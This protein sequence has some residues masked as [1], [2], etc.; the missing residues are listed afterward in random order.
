[1]VT[2]YLRR[3]YSSFTSHVI[4][5]PPRLLA[6]TL[7]LFL[8]VL[9][10]AKI[11]TDYLS[12]LIAANILAIFAASWDLLVGR[13]GL[14][15]LGHALFFGV[16]GY[17]TALLFKFYGLPLW[18]TIPIAI[19]VGGGVALAIGFPCL[20]VKGPYLALV[21]MAFPIILSRIVKWYPLS[22]VFGG[23]FGIRRL[24]GFFSFLPIRQ[25]RIAE[26]YLTL[27]LLF[28][29]SIAMY[30]VANSKTGIVF[31]SILD[32]EVAAKAS[33]I[34]VTKYK[35]MAFGI[36]GLF[37]S[38]AGGLQAHLLKVASPPMFD[39]TLSF[40]PIVVTF[41]GGIGTIYG[42]ILGAYIYYIIDR[43][44]LGDLLPSL[45]EL[46]S[47]FDYAKL[48]IF[49]IIV[50]ALVIKWPRGLARYTTDKLQDLEE[51]RDIDERGSRIWKK[52]KKKVKNGQSKGVEYESP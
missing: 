15:S 6:M 22:D 1:M 11:R 37:G 2:G 26:Y 32:D 46:P 42:P 48:M 31:I 16:G 28:I 19:L 38:V 50:V 12:M 4:D 23:E 36:S 35:L 34:N 20:R 27:S 3:A 9:P 44:V 40:L 52:Y 29:C 25:A 49:T 5:I 43:Y 30:K 13:T 39:L 18:V 10:V 24:P 51:A 7:F 17:S 47:E 8:L 41:L 14:I 33:G 45:V 21:T